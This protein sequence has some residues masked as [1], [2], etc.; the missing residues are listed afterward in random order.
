MDGPLVQAAP[1][2][3]LRLSPRALPRYSST[4]FK[5]KKWTNRMKKVGKSKTNPTFSTSSYCGRAIPRGW[6]LRVI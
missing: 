5:N 6:W 3:L 2:G 4:T 1:P